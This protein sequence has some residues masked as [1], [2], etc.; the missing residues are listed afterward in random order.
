MDLPNYFIFTLP[1]TQVKWVLGPERKVWV[2]NLGAVLLKKHCCRRE[3]RDRGTQWEDMVAQALLAE[4]SGSWDW[5]YPLPK[6]GWFWVQ[7]R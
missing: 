4:R 1:L 7:I 2:P 5:Q 3:Q 6:K